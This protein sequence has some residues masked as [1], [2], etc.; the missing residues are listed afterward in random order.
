MGQPQAWAYIRVSTKEQDEEVQR[1]AIEDFCTSRAITL[2]KIF[3]DK[4]ESGGK[5]FQERPSAKQLLDELAVEKP[6]AVIVWS[7]DRVGRSMIDTLSTIML[8]EGYGVK[9]I[10][11][12]EEW[13]QTLDDNVRK[14]ILSILTWVAE[15]ERRRIRERQ[16]EAWAQGKQKGRPRKIKREVVEK[17][18]R[19][20]QGLPLTSIL[21]I[22]RADGYTLGY[23]T[24]KRYVREL[25]A[26]N[27]NPKTPG[28]LGCGS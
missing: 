2:T 5:P 23:S 25:R 22:M 4:G 1:K 10:S 12:K 18:L 24:L 8:I 28:A 13:L 7:I 19:K 3:I 26:N 14:L 27:K 16:L 21:K 15:W 9:V 20:Y 6:Q 17:Y 11:V